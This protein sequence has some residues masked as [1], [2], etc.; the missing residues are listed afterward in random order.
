M[1]SSFDSNNFIDKWCR[2]LNTKIDGR[3]IVAVSGGIDSTVCALLIKKTKILHN[4]LLIDTG[5]LRKGEVEKVQDNFKRV[6]CSI[7]VIDAGDTFYDN[8]QGRSEFSEKR[9]AFRKTYFSILTEYI[10]GKKAKY[11]LQ[12]TQFH[13]SNA[14][15][16]HNNPYPK[17]TRQF[18]MLE[19]LA[20]LTKVQIRAIARKLGIPSEIIK[21]QPFPGPGLLLRFSGAYSHHKLSVIRDIT[22]LTEQFIEHHPYVFRDCYQVFPFLAGLEIPFVNLLSAGD[23]GPIVLMRIIKY[24]AGRKGIMYMPKILSETIQRKLVDELMQTNSIARVCFDA[25]PKYGQG[26]KSSPGGTIEYA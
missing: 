3:V 19:P 1:T 2:Q 11:L 10:K 21:R 20:G 24:K 12:G 17:K 6:K 8:V 22:Y 7:D 25:T 26:G 13:L 16:Y 9:E 5:F 15:M 23:H 14:K 18:K 4:L